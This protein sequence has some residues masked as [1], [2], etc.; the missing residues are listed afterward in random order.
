MPPANGTIAKQHLEASDRLRATN[1]DEAEGLARAAAQLA[2]QA[3]DLVLVATAHQRVAVCLLTR[4]DHDGC[5]TWL[6][7]ASKAAHES[8]DQALIFDTLLTRGVLQAN[9]GELVDA[10]RSYTEALDLAARS[11]GALPTTGVINNL[12]GVYGR[13][14]DFEAAMSCYERVL[15]QAVSAGQDHNLA[16]ALVN[17]GECQM[18]MD[19]L[20]EAR[21]CFQR[22]R[23]LLEHAD[24][25]GLRP[26]LLSGLG[27]LYSRDARHDEA[28]EL[29]DRAISMHR[30][31]HNRQGLL[32]ALSTRARILARRGDL[33][34][35]I[36]HLTEA[37]AISVEVELPAEERSCCADLS[38]LYA[39][40]DE[41]EEAY[42]YQLRIPQLDAQLLDVEKDRTIREITSRHET[43]IQRLRNVEL[44]EANTSLQRAY[45][46]IKAQQQ[47]L[48]LARDKAE[49]AARVQSEFL[50][51]MSHELRTPL[52]AVLGTSEI[53]Q[54]TPLDDE[55][56][57][58]VEVIT[59][60][61]DLTL[62]I[63]DDILDLAKLEAGA[64]ELDPR[65]LQLRSLIAAVCAIVAAR[66]D[67][68][69]VA[70]RHHVSDDVPDNLL[71]DGRRLRQVILNLASN[72]VKFTGEGRV[73]LIVS[74]E[75][76]H[77]RFE[78]LDNGV[79][80]DPDRV[81]E[82]FD[83][84]V[85]AESSELRNHGGTGL[86]LSI[87]K[88]F[89]S[90]FEGSIGAEPR[91]TGGSRFWFTAR[92]PAVD[93]GRAETPSLDAVPEP[94]Q[95]N[96]PAL[97]VLVVEDVP[98]NR[99]VLTRMLGMLGSTV[100]HA[101]HGAEAVARMREGGF[102]LVLMDCR[103]PVMDGYEATRRIRR[104]EQGSRTPIIALTAN[105]MAEHRARCLEA[106][107]DDVLT[108][109]LRFDV[110]RRMVV[111][112]FGVQTTP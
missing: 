79:G 82:L 99:M 89:V 75:G 93:R 47:E 56:R 107:M 54:R 61:G 83:P 39:Q 29:L 10:V 108:K 78:V 97:R 52:N 55:Q 80:I 103:M 84:F 58:L 28:V 11:E 88:R 71:G 12:G 92:M 62:A 8:R 22:A 24:P 72:A 15:E 95:D 76:E 111:A 90:L 70:L 13:M 63:V 57:G 67:A 60:A 17:M 23:P 110:L 25:Y 35:A 59:Q 32:Q 65:P 9:R 68:K 48:S 33:H 1:L 105:A 77:V 94:E 14:R 38:A 45:D 27:E 41:W 106:G 42:R 73:D 96:L 20:D 85:Q 21:S 6:G 26:Y 87:C 36:E 66:S 46:E 31:H 53:L 40:L 3:G 43:E 37:L 74:R 50:S 7:S 98:A 86:G 69:R 91:P 109:P 51:N 16:L 34:V 18:E 104:E 112:R 44:A 4:G 102:D 64:L 81:E 100:E 5:A 30:D 49:R 101:H 19:R 2:E